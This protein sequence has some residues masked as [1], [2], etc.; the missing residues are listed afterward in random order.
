MGINYRKLGEFSESIKELTKAIEI[1]ADRANVYNMI[2]LSHFEKQDYDEAVSN[3]SKAIRI[4]PLGAYY[5]N[6]ALATYK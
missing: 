6:R 2:G 4:E 3:F 1:Q 5:S